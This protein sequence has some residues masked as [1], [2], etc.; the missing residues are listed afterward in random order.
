M[1]RT[2][3]S[4]PDKNN[5]KLL[6]THPR[7]E[8]IL[9][10]LQESRYFKKAGK[11]VLRKVLQQGYLLHLKKDE[12]LIKDGDTMPPEMFILVEGTLDV[13]SQEKFILRLERPGDIAG[14]MSVIS[15]GPRSADVIAQ[16]DCEL[17]SFPHEVFKVQN[18]DEL[19]PVFY[20]LFAHILAEK[21]K[22]TTAQSMIRK[23]QRVHSSD[24][25]K[26]AIIDVNESDRMIIQGALYS[27]WSECEPVIYADPQEYLDSPLDHRF[28]LLIVD[29]QYPHMMESELAAVE[30]LINALK[31]HGAP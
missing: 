13:M 30:N 26:V 9:N 29:V 16:S 3:L 18:D 11:L 17:V 28:D 12:V 25:P 21:L 4:V 5:P 2:P 24:K 20:F 15:P 6:V 8:V 19:V 23:N 27:E 7:L 10:I 22:L 1:L 31:V 14:E